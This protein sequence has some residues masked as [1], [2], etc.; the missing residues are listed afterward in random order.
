[1]SEEI[2]KENRKQEQ[3]PL[4]CR[5]GESSPSSPPGPKGQGGLLPPPRASKLL[6]GMP[7][8][9]QSTQ[10]SLPSPPAPLETS[11]RAT[12]LLDEHASIPPL[13]IHPHPLS[14]QA[15][16]RAERRRRHGL[17]NSWPPS[18]PRRTELSTVIFV[19]DFVFTQG[20]APQ[21]ELEHTESS[22]R[23]RRTRKLSSS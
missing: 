7:P 9:Q 1:M 12:Q 11:N 22:P 5:L 20:I 6:G 18:S 21:I 8:S 10:L 16:R 13:W 17:K 4:T 14:R 15:R 2:E 19:L 3:N 23:P